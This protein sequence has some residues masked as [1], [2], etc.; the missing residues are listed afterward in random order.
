MQTEQFTKVQ[1]KYL[2]RSLMFNNIAGSKIPQYLQEHTFARVSYLTKLQF[3]KFR[4]ICRKTPAVEFHFQLSCRPPAGV[5]FLY[6]LK[7]CFLEITQISI[8]IGAISLKGKSMSFSFSHFKASVT[9]IS[10]N[11]IALE[12]LFP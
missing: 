10:N 5:G 3:K 7:I 6:I 2:C 8:I 12:K 11:F 9:Q 4:K 1:R